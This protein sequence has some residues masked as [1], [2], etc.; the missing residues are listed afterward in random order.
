MRAMSR[1]RCTGGLAKFLSDFGMI[2]PLALRPC[3]LWR[4]PAFL[5]PLYPALNP[6]CLEDVIERT[7]FFCNSPFG[8]VQPLLFVVA[9]CLVELSVLTGSCSDHSRIVVGS[10]SD[11]PRTLKDVSARSANLSHIL[12]CYFRGRGNIW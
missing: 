8:E 2:G 7:G 6:I 9:Q 11:R 4:G 1:G 5:M 10:W 3:A 12:D